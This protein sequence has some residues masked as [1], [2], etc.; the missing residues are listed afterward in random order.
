MSSETELPD[1]VNRAAEESDDGIVDLSEEEEEDDEEEMQRVREGF[2]VDDEEDD[3]GPRK[4]KKKRR[5]RER[6]TEEGLDEDDLDLVL[7]NTGA[8]PRLRGGLKRLKK[9]DDRPGASKGSGALDDIFSDEDEDAD[10]AIPATRDRHQDE[11]EDFIEEDLDEA[12]EDDLARPAP[13]K[14]RTPVAPQYSDVDQEKLDQ[15]YEIFGDGEDYQWALDLEEQDEEEEQEGP[16]VPKLTDV[17]EKTELKERMLTEEDNIVRVTDVPERY[18]EL[19]S[20]FKSYELT[21]QELAH[22]KRWVQQILGAEKVDFLTEH[23][24]LQP[25]NQAVSDVLGFICEECLEVP[26]IWTHRRDFITH[27]EKGADNQFVIRDLLTEDD[28][29]RVVTLDIEYHSFAAKK[30]FV[31]ELLKRVGKLDEYKSDLDAVT[32][33]QELT[34]FQEYVLFRFLDSLK[35]EGHEL[36]DIDEEAPKRRLKSRVNG[37]TAFISRLKSTGAYQFVEKLGISASQVATN[38]AL[39]TR[40]H[41]TT[42]SPEDPDKLL[43][44]LMPASSYNSVR[45]L[46]TAVQK[47]FAEELFHEPKIRATV[48]DAFAQFSVVNVKL[49]EKGRVKITKG[50]PNYDFKFLINKEITSFVEEPDLFLRMIK[51]EEDHLITIEI[52]ILEYDEFVEH[53]F[54]RLLAL[55]GLSEVAIKWDAVRK[56]CLSQAMVQLAKLAS[57]NVKDDLLRQC[58]NKLFYAVRSSVLKQ[59]NQAPYRPPGYAL[60]AI[61]STLTVSFGEGN[62]MDAVVG[63]FLNEYGEAGKFFKIDD[64]PLRNS[65][66]FV[67]AFVEK[68]RELKPD[69]IGINGYNARTKKLYNIIHDAMEKN[70]VRV[71]YSRDADYLKY[72]NGEPPIV[73]VVF[74]PDDIA[75]RYETSER[76][77]QE[78][79]NVSPLY[80]YCVA[81]GRYLQGPLLEYV[82]LGD[83]VSSVLFHRHQHLLGQTLLLQAIRT[84]LVDI[85]NLVGVDIN[86]AIREPYYGASLQYVAGLGPRKASG[87]VRA[88]ANKR[89]LGLVSRLQLVTLQLTPKRVFMNCASFLKIVEDTNGRYVEEMVVLDETRIH[90]EDYGLATKMAADALELD[91]EDIDDMERGESVIRRL[92]EGRNMEKLD[93]LILEDYALELQK[94]RGKRKRAT[95]HMIKEELQS[96]YDELRASFHIMTLREVFTLLT[97]E[98]EDTFFPGVVCTVVLKRVSAK[99]LA[100]TTQFSVEVNIPGN[101]MF[102]RKETRGV[103]EI[104]HVRQ[105]VPAKVLEIDYDE[106]TCEASVLKVDVENPAQSAADRPRNLSEWD[107]EAEQRS[108]EQE[109]VRLAALQPRKHVKHVFFHNFTSKQAEEYLAPMARGELVIRPSSRGPNHLA[110]TWKVDQNLYQHLDVV[111]RVTHSRGGGETK[112]YMV[113]GYKYSDLDELVTFHVGKLAKYVEQMTSN[114]RF[115]KRL[116]A[117]CEL[118]LES[119]IKANSGRGYYI[120]SYDHKRPGWFLLL[121]KGSERSKVNALPV[122]VTPNGYKLYSYEY[123]LV[124]LLSNGFKKLMQAEH[125]KRRG[126]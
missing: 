62:P 102:E 25:F 68:V 101:K 47:A 59:V 6:E 11:M 111:E 114:D 86:R 96:H 3:V 125:D 13:K 36:E 52:N 5:H 64:S 99:Y 17:F 112:T 60:G 84:V 2:I 100:G 116:R 1:Y 75:R 76:G 88:I 19:R 97:G 10:E 40:A 4:R 90:P 93:D 89:S 107:E 87:L 37:K 120:F 115:Q 35:A 103:D 69:V 73:E 26:F 122:E 118:Y 44:D 51:A 108:L 83:E 95:L 42:D 106:F 117:E 21:P 113:H 63:V 91:E 50:T 74:V 43:E 65:D 38:F 41:F 123:A 85:V 39:Q 30:R 77:V 33:P 55:G 70:D 14:Y 121:F 32:K 92:D 45:S 20:L 34:D 71:P 124:G 49:T 98:T 23:D 8:A 53:L 48:R 9:A 80:R 31:V 66:K 61:P 109:R 24:L 12:G 58:T 94:N 22:E 72:A 119:Y 18:Q 105:A 16:G 67:E 104:F 46:K 27:V 126:R 29:W 82:N 15:L 54:Q 78:F 79:P 28:L 7:E 81:L 57:V 110:V 56:E